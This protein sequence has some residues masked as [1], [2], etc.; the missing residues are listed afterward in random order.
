VGTGFP[1]K[2]RPALKL[3]RIARVKEFQRFLNALQRMFQ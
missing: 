3:E 1:L 2:M